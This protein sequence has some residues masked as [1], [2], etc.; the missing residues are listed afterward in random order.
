[1]IK[2]IVVW[3]LKESAHGNTKKQNALIIKSKLE[4]LSGKIS[5]LIKLEVGIDFSH[6]ESSGDIILY[7]EFESTKDLENY[8]SHPNH[9][10]IIPFVKET[11]SERRVVDYEI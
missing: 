4:G 10:A 2:H 9:Q 1:M 7:S 6:T 3:R 5:G 8:Q 11:T